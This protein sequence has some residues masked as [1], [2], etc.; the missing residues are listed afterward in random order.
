[1]IT[2]SSLTEKMSKLEEELGHNRKENL[3]LEEKNN[4]LKTTVSSQTEQILQLKEELSHQ[5]KKK[6]RIR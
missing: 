5:N 2:V 3:D 4:K 1:M 6:I